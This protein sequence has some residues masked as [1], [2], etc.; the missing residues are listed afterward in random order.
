MT[1]D[2]PE[3]RPTAKW[4]PITPKMRIVLEALEE[5]EDIIHC[6]T[7][8]G[9]VM[10]S[11]GSRAVLYAA[12]KRG[13]ARRYPKPRSL[14]GMQGDNVPMYYRTDA[15]TQALETGLASGAKTNEQ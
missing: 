4:R 9:E 13:Y 11:G 14:G 7:S 2:E 10:A 6:G 15:G 12:V 3:D 1:T 5:R 8:A